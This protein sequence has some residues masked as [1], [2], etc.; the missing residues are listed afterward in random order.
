MYTI[1]LSPAAYAQAEAYAQSHNLSIG[2]V[3]ERSLSALAARGRTCRKVKADNP[4]PSG[5]PW[6][7]DETNLAHFREAV[8][9]SKRAKGREFTLEEVDT[10]LGL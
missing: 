3:V 5:D 10:L 9:A 8:A 7:D 4:S 6:F 2:E 1:T